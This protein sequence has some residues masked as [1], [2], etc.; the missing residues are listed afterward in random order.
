MEAGVDI[1]MDIGYKNISK[2]DSEEQFMEELTAPV[3][4]A[5]KYISSGWMILRKYIE[6]GMSELMID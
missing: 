5:A 6:M 1:D 4:E 2:L 3:C